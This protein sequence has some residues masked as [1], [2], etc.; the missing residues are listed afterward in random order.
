[1]NFDQKAA[2]FLANFH[3][4]GGKHWTHG[5]LRQT[6]LVPPLPA[7]AGLLSGL[8]PE[9]GATWGETWP[10]GAQELPAGPRMHMGPLTCTQTLKERLPERRPRIV[11]DPDVPGPAEYQVPD[12]S[13]RESSPHPRFS[14]S[15]KREGGGCR[16]WQTMWFQSESPFTQKADFH[17]EQKVG[18]SPQPAPGRCRDQTGPSPDSFHVLPGCRLQ[19]PRPPAF[20]RAAGPSSSAACTPGPATCDV[21]NRGPAAPRVVIR[22]VRRPRRHDM[23]PFCTL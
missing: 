20:S 1:M 10:L 7:A 3:I 17:R 11:A 14:I 6:T 2:K 22:G 15:R 13:I 23:G 19:S 18:A 8:Q 16:A 9:L 12:A 21:E 4:Y 5:P